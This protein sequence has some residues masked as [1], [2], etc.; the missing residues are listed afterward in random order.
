MKKLLLILTAVAVTGCVGVPVARKFPDTPEALKQPCPDLQ[1]VTDDNTKLS[2]LMTV[3]TDNYK[4]YNECQIKVESWQEWYS[5][6]KKIF[7]DAN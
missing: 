5:T 3:V 7:E 4:M 6:Q 2:T 1:T